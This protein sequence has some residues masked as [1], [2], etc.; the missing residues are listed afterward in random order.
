M[1]LEDD[2]GQQRRVDRAA[3]FRTV[4]D[5]SAVRTIQPVTSSRA[6]SMRLRPETER[7][8]AIPNPQTVKYTK[9]RK[10]ANDLIAR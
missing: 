4:L 7:S 10:M 5:F 1:A 3:P 8:T 2:R 6:S 9:A